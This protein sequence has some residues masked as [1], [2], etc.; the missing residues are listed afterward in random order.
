MTGRRAVKAK[1]LDDLKNNVYEHEKGI[2]GRARKTFKDV[3]ELTQLEKMKFVK[4][5]EKM[6]SMQNT[7]NRNLTEYS[8]FFGGTAFEKNMWM[9]S[10][11]KY[12]KHLLS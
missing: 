4:S 12:R 9:R 8:R 2:H 6:I 7:V 11:K 1:T 5:K 3:F 10:Q